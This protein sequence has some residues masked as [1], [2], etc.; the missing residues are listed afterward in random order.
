MVSGTKFGNKISRR[1]C[2]KEDIKLYYKEDIYK[3]IL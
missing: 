1:N 3:I 2:E